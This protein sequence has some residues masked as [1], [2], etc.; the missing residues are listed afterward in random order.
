MAV[1]DDDNLARAS[2]MANLHLRLFFR[3]LRTAFWSSNRF[4]SA[5]DGLTILSFSDY[6]S[7]SCTLSTHNGLA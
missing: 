1:D 7:P 6:L 3:P 4:V 5:I 2:E